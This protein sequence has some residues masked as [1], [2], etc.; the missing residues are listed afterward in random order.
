MRI[1][2]IGSG[3]REHALAW[4]I[5]QSPLVNK[6]FIAPGNGGTALC[7]E[8]VPIK[9]NDLT[10]LVKFAI[11]QKIDLAVPGPELPLVLG[12]CDMMEKAGIPC[13]GPSK[14]A[15][16][17]EGSKIFAKE[18]MRD[19]GVPTADFEIFDNAAGAK[20]YIRAKGLP[21]VIKADGL[22][23]G[24]GVVVARTEEE[25][26]Q[27]VEQML[28]QKLFGEA[29]NR[30]VIEETLVGEE[31]SFLAFCAGEEVLPLPS[32]QDHKPVFDN[33][34]GP[35]TGGMGAYSPAPVLPDSEIPGVI[36]MVMRPVLRVMAERGHPFKGI[37]YAGLMM[38]ENGPKVLEFN[39]RFGDPEC[40]P[41]LMRLDADLVPIMLS[42]AKGSLRGLELPLSPL[43]A[44][45]VVAAAK[46]YPGDYPKGME[47]GGIEEA[48]ALAEPGRIKV[49]QAGTKA[50]GGKSVSS[51]GRILGITALAEGLEEAKALAYKAVSQI[52]MENMH[53]RSDIGDKGIRRLRGN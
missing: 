38:T 43:T 33:D 5:S 36:D 34:S 17:L 51:G 27:A 44:L 41:L 46:G 9:D 15:A 4:K 53:C 29:G 1:L 2:L 30:I 6:L 31:A 3:G 35:N 42:C 39:T 19:A 50:E 28:N 26:F 32:A 48:E 13:F 47:I 24:K 25:A 18:V 12:I 40:Q 8:N 20:D 21:L 11:E 16:Q 45:C 14:Y 52:R 37:L 7:G 23:A 49:F 22:A 10:G